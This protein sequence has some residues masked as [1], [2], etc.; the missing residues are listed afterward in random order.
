MYKAEI[1][2][3]CGNFGGIGS[4]PK[5]Y[6]MGN[7]KEEAFTLLDH[8][9]FLGIK[10]FDTANSYGG[11]LSEQ[12]LGEW[13]TRQ[14]RNFRSEII[15]STKV[16]NP[17]GVIQRGRDV[18][19]RNE[20]LE[21]I[22]RSLRRLQVDYIDLVYVHELTNQVNPDEV[23]DAFST[24]RQQGKINFMGLSN[25]SQQDVE[26]FFKKDPSASASLIKAVQNEFN[27]LVDHDALELIPWL[28]GRGI[29]YVAF[30]PLAG[31]LLTTTEISSI[32]SAPEESRLRLFSSHYE[33]FFT[34][35]CRAKILALGTK[36]TEEQ[37]S[38][39]YLALEFCRSAVGVSQILISPKSL[40]QF[41]TLGLTINEL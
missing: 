8:C 33:R 18:L 28:S 14:S 4:H 7:S 15:L 35:P 31:G 21:N 25:V 24:A 27:L 16:G 39:A 11:G 5:F 23:L 13:I 29:D 10:R 6:G 40:R 22:E 2:F 17:Y 41:D 36:A 1:G 20:I 38:M 34:D 30:G 9:R 37:K 3:G 26:D 19:S 32:I 12:F